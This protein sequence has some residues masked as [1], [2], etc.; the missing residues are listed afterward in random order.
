MHI[1]GEKVSKLRVGFLLGPGGIPRWAAEMLEQIRDSDYACLSLLVEGNGHSEKKDVFSRVNQAFYLW[2]LRLDRKRCKPSPDALAQCDLRQLFPETALIE[3]QPIRQ[4]FA[5]PFTDADVEK[6]I[7]S[8][9]DVL[10]D[11]GFRRLR[12]RILHSARYGTWTFQPGEAYPCQ[13]GPV[14]FWEVYDS[15][16]ETILSLHVLR[17]DEEGDIQICRIHTATDYISVTRNENK[18]LWIAS[19]LLPRKIRELHALGEKV[20]FEKVG[21]DNN[22]EPAASRKPSAIPKSYQ[23]LWLLFKTTRKHYAKKIWKRIG[24]KQW[25]LMYSFDNQGMPP[26]GLE[27]YHPIIPPKDRLWA[28]PH[29][30][31]KDG[32]Y[33]VF[34]EELIYREVKGH[35]SCLTIDHAGNFTPPRPVIIQPYHLSYPFVFCHQDKYFMVPETS[36]NRTI[37]LYECVQFPDRWQRVR[38]L[39]DNV[40]AVDATLHQKDGLWWLFTNIRQHE[41]TS[42]WDDLYLFSAPHLFEARWTPHPMNPVVS[43]V[44]SARPA[45]RLFLHQG[46]LYRPSQDSS[47]RYGYRI[48][49]NQVL[50]LN[51]SRYEEMSVGVIEPPAGY[52]FLAAHTVN[53]SG[54]LTVIDSAIMRFTLFH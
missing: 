53:S 49:I 12:G 26:F 29:V 33:Y 22:E 27:H 6:I 35:I 15:R 2:Y 20:F 16:P 51:E 30:I 54:G 7:G 38:V 43:D 37:E 52:K 45:G 10:V 44:R 28:D 21:R 42:D 13:G 25:I 34:I 47:R 18:L 31:Q 1:K 23:T 3:A 19:A 17:G 46:K 24:L 11:L 50:T 36:E 48:R 41:G 9:L 5:Y 4:D 8:D 32:M 39:M 14:G 40:W